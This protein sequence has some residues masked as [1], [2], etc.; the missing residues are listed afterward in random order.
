MTLDTDRQFTGDARAWQGENASHRPKA[1]GELRKRKSTRSTWLSFSARLQLTVDS[2]RRCRRYKI[3]CSGGQPC[4]PCGRRNIQCVFID[5]LRY[6]EEYVQELQRRVAAAESNRNQAEQ[7]LDTSDTTLPTPPACGPN[8]QNDDAGG[9]NQ[10]RNTQADPACS[11]PPS[12]SDIALPPRSQH[13]TGS[14]GSRLTDHVNA[15]AIGHGT[16][17]YIPDTRGRASK[18]H[19]LRI[20]AFLEDIR[21]ARDT[22]DHGM[23]VLQS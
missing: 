20:K 18:L 23:I 10:Q 2:C 8:H 1:D 13:R 12:P 19:F 15:L 22:P 16:S 7:R 11:P 5:R 21:G 14:R 9:S 4:E 3:K 6:S 17:F